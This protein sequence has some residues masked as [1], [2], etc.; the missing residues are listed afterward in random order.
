MNGI[1]L[2]DI[3]MDVFI[4]YFTKENLGVSNFPP[5]MV[6]KKN[7][8]T[9]TLTLDGVPGFIYKSF[10]GDLTE[11][12]NEKNEIIYNFSD[13]DVL[14]ADDI[15][16]TVSLPEL[17]FV[18]EL[19]QKMTPYQY[20]FEYNFDTVEETFKFITLPSTTFPQ[21]GIIRDSRT[22]DALSIESSL[23]GSVD[24]I[25]TSSGVYQVSQVLTGEVIGLIYENNKIQ[26]HKKNAAGEYLY[27]NG[28]QET[29]E[30][31]SQGS[32]LKYKALRD[33]GL[34]ILEKRNALIYSKIS[35]GQV[36]L[37]ND[38]QTE[39]LEFFQT[40]KKL[41]SYEIVS[42]PNPVP[43]SYRKGI[44][45]VSMSTT[46]DET[47]NINKTLLNISSLIQYNF[48]KVGDNLTR[49]YTSDVLPQEGE[50]IIANIYQDHVILKGRDIIINS[51]NTIAYYTAAG[52]T[53]VQLIRS[54]QNNKFMRIPVKV[55][56]SVSVYNE[57][58]G[59]FEDIQV[60]KSP[61]S[62][63]FILNRDIDGQN[64]E[65]QKPIT[66]YPY[67]YI[68]I[69]VSVKPL[70]FKTYIGNFSY[71]ST[72][73][74]VTISNYVVDTTNI[75]IQNNFGNLGY[76][77]NTRVSYVQD[78]YD[79]T[80][81]LK[82]TETFSLTAGT[83]VVSPTINT[84]I[85]NDFK[86]L[87]VS[88]NISTLI[89]RSVTELDLSDR[90]PLVPGGTIRKSKLS[91]IKK[92]VPEFLN[93]RYNDFYTVDNIAYDIDGTMKMRI[94]ADGLFEMLTS[95]RLDPSNYKKRL[96]K[97]S[98]KDIDDSLILGNII[99]Y[100]SMNNYKTGKIYDSNLVYSN[101]TNEIES[102]N[103][104]QKLLDF[105]DFPSDILR[106]EYL[107]KK[108]LRNLIYEDNESTITARDETLIPF[109]DNNRKRISK[110]YFKNILIDS[111]VNYF[112]D[113]GINQTNEKYRD[114]YEKYYKDKMDNIILDN[115]VT[116]YQKDI[117]QKK[118]FSINN[119]VSQETLLIK[120]I[121]SNINWEVL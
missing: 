94:Y 80:L 26:V 11:A 63:R 50:T 34:S 56:N 17:N 97:I 3:P 43:T 57:Q 83:P 23:I 112:S 9:Y 5:V 81:F 106:E 68:D 114:Q 54:V 14:E 8:Y 111:L 103:S 25:E 24:I 113:F 69:I 16:G 104:F 47:L 96:E 107:I 1:Y 33:S 109:V 62:P 101:V 32:F 15:T 22:G 84:V 39:R 44:V 31:Q 73:D 70:F 86:K 21:S 30:S 98:Y 20:R 67:G 6:D 7:V 102:L 2:N 75:N 61:T 48:K 100:A 19:D 118:V 27:Y 4:K 72:T 66:D 88:T 95:E 52:S 93:N 49:L 119:N 46:P 79:E 65:V 38:G 13:I 71:N 58:K 115:I 12:E 110:L 76:T 41:T 18:Y 64:Y 77:G 89:N 82:T 120:L 35:P 29:T 59:A 10:I 105:E 37:I 53:P 28:V 36:A 55:N 90:G 51:N 45:D 85:L 108:N 42:N 117:S 78:V 99:E 92:M 40:F 74:I 87:F 121:V 91:V 116:D 60:I